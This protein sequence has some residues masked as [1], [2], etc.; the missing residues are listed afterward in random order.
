MR[1]S[2]QPEDNLWPE[3]ETMAGGLAR[4]GHA[5]KGQQK[6]ISGWTAT[7]MAGDHLHCPAQGLNFLL[8]KPLSV[9]VYFLLLAQC[10]WASNPYCGQVPCCIYLITT[11]ET[12]S[13]SWEKKWKHLTGIES[14]GCAGHWGLL[15][16]LCHSVLGQSHEMGLLLSFYWRGN[17]R[18]ERRICQL[19]K[20]VVCV[21]VMI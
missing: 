1:P 21:C 12:S 14:F 5:L 13:M 20:T 18:S 10:S 11:P 16:G 7:E 3:A 2:N 4:N 6:K 15:C 9:P 17:W 8:S 19:Y